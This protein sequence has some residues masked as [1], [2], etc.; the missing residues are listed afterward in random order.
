[1]KSISRVLFLIL[2]TT[3]LSAADNPDLQVITRIRQEGF[4]N[5]KVMQYAQTLTDTIGGRLF[6]WPVWSSDLP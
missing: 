3:S 1:M 6:P 4:R 5:S 2:F